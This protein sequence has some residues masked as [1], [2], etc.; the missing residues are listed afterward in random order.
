MDV[1]KKIKKART[2]YEVI[3][4]FSAS[5]IEKALAVLSDYYYN[6]D[7]ELIDDEEF[8]ALVD[9]LKK[10]NPKSNY[11][12][13]IGA[14]IRGA[15][16]KLPYHMG[17][18][19][20]IK[21]QD[22]LD[23]VLPKKNIEYVISDKLDGV[24]CMFE[25]NDGEVKMYTRGNGTEGQDISHLKELINIDTDDIVDALQEDGVDTF[26][27]RGELIIQKKT[28]EKKY[29][30]IMKNGRNMV[31]GIV[32]SKPT[33]VNKKHAHDV[34]FVAYEIVDTE[35]TTSEQMEK[36]EEYNFAVVTWAETDSKKIDIDF[37]D[38]YLKK[39]KERSAYE[40]DG[41][42]AIT[43]EDHTVVKSGNPDF[44]FAYKG[45]SE[46]AIT[47]VTSVVWNPQ[48]DGHIIP[49]IL[50]KPVN[51]SGATLAKTSG[52]NAR[53]INDNMIGR[54]AQIEIIR[55]GDT[56]PY[57]LDIIKPVKKPDFPELAYHWDDNEV[58]IILDNP[59]DD[60]AVMVTR[61]TKFVT[62]IKVEN[63]SEGIVRKIFDAGHDTI[64][65]IISL[66]VDDLLEIEGFKETLANKIIDNLNKS[67]D[68]LD[69][70]G[71]MVAS[72]CFGRGFGNRKL[73]RILNEYPSIAD[74]YEERHRKKWEKKIS[75][76]DGFDVR[77]TDLFLDALPDFQEFYGDFIAVRPI[78][79]YE[80]PEIDAEGGRF[81]DQVV[82]FTGFRSD[83]WKTIIET[84]GGR[85]ASSFSGK[86][87]LLVYKAGEESSSK[88]KDAQAKGI[89]SLTMDQFKDQFNLPD[90]K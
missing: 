86:V 50:Y 41:I 9:R 1:I 75:D 68:N 26:Y 20:K 78:N 5:D 48:K 57:I 4:S 47:T 12:K 89:Q 39:R 34:D 51:L 22:G 60:E 6:R 15:K 77:T 24:S 49:T 28:F 67:L 88:F 79:N 23:K 18:M 13:N 56:I 46:T 70:L 64:L 80:P 55:S 44:A 52:F 16:V 85:L 3:R 58:N 35:L 82:L 21:N 69:M 87:T 27:V 10:L 25:Y 19:D 30:S 17:S 90:Y 33:S 76:L 84:E 63:M 59:D 73:K 38:K 61:L 11:F 45:R 2:I 37:L 36:L 81:I 7:E 54:G 53:F 66:E 71:L 65:K 32:N 62:D 14:P 42:I 72:N 29:S 83:P 43:N 31:A 74:E 40:I 8:D